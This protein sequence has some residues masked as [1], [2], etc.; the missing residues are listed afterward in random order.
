M[1]GDA[2]EAGDPFVAQRQDRV[3]RGRPRIEILDRDHAMGLI[4]IEGVAAEP[5]ERLLGLRSHA[6]RLGAARLAG[7]EQA[8]AHGRD[9][10][11]DERLGLPVARR[12]VEVVHAGGERELHG[13]R[14]CLRRLVGERS[15]TEDGE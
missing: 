6:T 5:L 14:R 15:R 8:I 4:Q 3:E 9:E 10:W 12:D 1:P 2:G 13:A 7:D 11:A